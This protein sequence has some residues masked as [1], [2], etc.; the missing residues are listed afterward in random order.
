MPQ[1]PGQRE[2]QQ[3]VS[4]HSGSLSH[5]EGFRCNSRPAR[6]P[7]HASAPERISSVSHFETRVVA[8][9]GGYITSCSLYVVPV[10]CRLVR[11]AHVAWRAAQSGTEIDSQSKSVTWIRKEV[12]RPMR[13]TTRYIA[14]TANTT[15]P[16]SADAATS[17][18]DTN[19]PLMGRLRE[20]TLEELRP[21]PV[22]TFDSP[23]LRPP[24]T[25]H[26]QTHGLR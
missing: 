25:R 13:C 22:A 1:L 21:A 16:A 7:V 17:A 23:T 5:T 2:R 4:V 15:Q 24:S 26:P 9:A 8:S 19:C 3:H 18:G 12:V 10:L 20:A 6:S 14:G 11:G